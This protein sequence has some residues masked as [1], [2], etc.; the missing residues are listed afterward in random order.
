MTGTVRV[1]RRLR[2]RLVRE[3]GGNHAL[4]RQLLAEAVTRR[5]LAQ[6]G[7]PSWRTAEPPEASDRYSLLLPGWRR[8]LVWPASMPAPGFDRMAAARC[9]LAVQ[10][11]LSSGGGVVNG[12]L[13]LFDLPRLPPHLTPRGRPQLRPAETLPKVIGGSRHPRM[14]LLWGLVRILV[15][16]EPEPPPPKKGDGCILNL[17]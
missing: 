11:K 5:W 10:A 3:A 1:R 6:L 17:K 9:Q 16:G 7:I 14:R 8:A 2:L 4:F 15:G 13:D 12:W